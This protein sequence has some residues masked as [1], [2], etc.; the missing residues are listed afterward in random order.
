MKNK[1]KKLL[2]LACAILLIVLIQSIGITYAKYI[3][4]DR[5]TGHAEVAKWAFEIVKDGEQTK[6]INLA[7]T[8]DNNTLVNGKIAPGTSGLFVIGVDSTGAEVDME[9]TVGF[10]NEQN[11]P[12]NLK[13][14][15]MGKEYKTLSEIL[16]KGVVKHDEKTRIYELPVVWRWE[17][18]T[19]STQEEKAINNDLD[20]QAANTITQYTFDIIATATQR[21]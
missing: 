1:T 21:Q 11:K 9:F 5:T 3:S 8:V 18:E 15:Y 13:F 16:M 20:T 4:G 2:G 19:G 10:D 12:E 14:I 7:D 17:Y 6:T